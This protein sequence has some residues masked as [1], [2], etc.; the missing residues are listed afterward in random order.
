MALTGRAITTRCGWTGSSWSA[1]P[2]DVLV[3]GYGGRT[4]NRLRLFSARSSHDFDMQ[5][6]NDGDYLR[7]VEQKI[8]SET[9]SKVLYPSDAMRIRPGTASHPGVF[10]RRLQP[11]RHHPPV[12][13]RPRDA[14]MHFRRR[15]PS[16]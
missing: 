5:I 1:I 7:A 14:S 9:I 11:A 8:A 16:I 2:Y 3:V 12:R 6:F 15:S 4:V 10:P 13:T